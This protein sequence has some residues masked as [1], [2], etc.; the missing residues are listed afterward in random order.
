MAQLQISQADI[1]NAVAGETTKLLANLRK[2]I[3]GHDF[4]PGWTAAPPNLTFKHKLGV[5]P[6]TVHVYGSNNKNGENYTALT[7]HTV[8]A[9][10]ITVSGGYAYYRPLANR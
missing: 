9:N 6:T 2:A 7:G 3:Q 5:V 10:T 4:D 8:D 1:Q